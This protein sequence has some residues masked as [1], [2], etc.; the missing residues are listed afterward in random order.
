MKR[1]GIS[2]AGVFLASMIA[3]CGGG[4]DEGPPKD[5]TTDPQPANFKDT[6]KK[7][8]GNMANQKRPTGKKAEAPASTPA[9]AAEK[10]GHTLI[11]SA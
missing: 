8:A 5:G 4:L 2:C 3:G 10:R 6:M 7:Y 11:D 9:P 1:F